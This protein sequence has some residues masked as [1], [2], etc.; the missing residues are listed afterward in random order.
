MDSTRIT[1]TLVKASNKSLLL[2]G[3]LN[4]LNF[5]LSSMLV[6][7]RQYDRVKLVQ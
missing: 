6:D 3:S 2:K 7:S 4:K 5:F 1:Q